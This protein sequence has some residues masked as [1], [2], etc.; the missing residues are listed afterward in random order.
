M[1][2]ILL[3]N[4]QSLENKIDDLRERINYQWDIQ[5]CIILC[6]TESWMNDDIISIQLAGYTLYRQ[7]R[8]AESG[9]TMVGGLCIFVN[10]SWC[11]ISKEVSRFCSPEMENLMIS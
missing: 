1:N 2:N 4:L 5:N 9:K 10:N 6:F 11:T 7:D 3:A 8:T